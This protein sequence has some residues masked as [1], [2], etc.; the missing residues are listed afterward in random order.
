MNTASAP[1]SAADLLRETDARMGQAL[2]NFFQRS[3]GQIQDCVLRALAQEMTPGFLAIGQTCMDWVS[4]Y[5]DALSTALATQFRLNLAHPET[6]SRQNVTHPA[7]L[8]LVDDNALRRQLAEDKAGGQLT[9]TLLSE[10]L[11]L[12]GRL[13]VVRQAV[14]EEPEQADAYGPRAIVRAMSRAFDELGIEKHIGTFLLRCATAPLVDTL[15]HTYTGLNQ[16]LGAHGIEAQAAAAPPA[17]PKRADQG[18]GR[19]VLSHIQSVATGTREALP[20]GAGTPPTSAPLS[21]AGEARPLLPPSRLIDHLA[22]WQPSVPA[23]APLPG[24]SPVPALR[25]LQN[26]PAVSGASAMD[27]AVLDASAGLFEY[28]LDDPDVSPRYRTQLERLQIPA[29]RAAL[30]SPEFFSDDHHPARQLIDLLGLF[31]RRFPESSASHVS[32]LD[33]VDA[34]S[35][36]IL[37]D[38]GHPVEAFSRAHAQLRAWF[39]DEDAR[40]GSKLAPEVNQLEQIERQE[41]G[42]LLALENLQDLTERYP[43][44]E[45]VLRRLEAAWVPYMASLY[46]A[47]AGEGPAWRNACLTMLQ[48]FLSLQAPDSDARE[49]RLQSIPRI[50][51]ELRHGLLAQGATPEQLRDFFSAIT[52]TQECWIRPAM[53]QQE[54]LVSTF[55]PRHSVEDIQ[56]LAHRLAEAPAPDSALAQAQQLLEGDWVD[57]DPPYEGL[58]TAR[59]AWVGVHGYLLFC[60]GDGERR[61]SLDCENLA[62]EIRGGRARIPEQSLSRKA[63]LRLRQDLTALPT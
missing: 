51:A 20:S 63:M 9:E 49:A 10:M 39:D 42:T 16:Y 5:P 8:Q 53:G 45:S 28:L 30:A 46:V 37:G 50:N 4:A 12:T 19:D 57:F 43:A 14:P 7:E 17:L 15:R 40:A 62:S 38:P 26:E 58:A 48:L 22:G 41:L 60:D 31:S 59:V 29:L 56:S 11:L 25:Q 2:E 36:T 24:I 54:T 34:A 23:A 55:V 47:E 13:Q 33:Q 61:F 27:L 3:R 1:I 32:A 18:P 52:A 21:P 44:P 35:A 6:F